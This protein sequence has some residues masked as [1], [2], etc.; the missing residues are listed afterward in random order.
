[1]IF[2]G[3]T[4]KSFVFDVYG[5]HTEEQRAFVESVINKNKKLQ[6]HIETM[7]MAYDQ[8]I[9]FWPEYRKEFLDQLEIFFPN[10][11]LLINYFMK[12]GKL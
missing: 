9:H 7:L 11:L 1:M 12:Y 5:Q 3:Y 6:E 10:D 4:I 2:P 8:E